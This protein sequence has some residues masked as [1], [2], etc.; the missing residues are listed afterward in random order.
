MGMANTDMWSPALEPEGQ[1]IIAEPGDD[2]TTT[3][4]P[5]VTEPEAPHQPRRG[6]PNVTRQAV[7]R[8]LAVSHLDKRQ[9]DVLARLVGVRD[10]GTG[11]DGVARVVLASLASGRAGTTA[12]R[13]LG[14]AGADALEAGVLA[15]E[16]AADRTALTSA[17]SALVALEA[18]EGPVPARRAGLA[19][20]GAV[21]SLT[22]ARRRDL[23]AVSG[24]LDV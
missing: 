5:E 4:E 20:A 13:L 8:T 17:W 3:A 19:L 16:L 21:Q 14:I 11:D 24:A 12:R 18:S 22:P 10:V 15:A 6:R 7:L 23:G 2:E 9:R 1:T